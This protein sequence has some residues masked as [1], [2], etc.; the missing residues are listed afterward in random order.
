MAPTTLL[1]QKTTT[2]PRGRDQQNE[3]SPLKVAELIATL[4]APV[5]VE[6][7][8]ITDPKQTNRVRRAVRK[9]LQVQ[10]ENKG[11]SLIEILSAC[12]SGWKMT[13]V[14]AKQWIDDHMLK[15]YPLGVF[16]DKT[17][18]V[19]ASE[20]RKNVFITT[21]L[22]ETIDIPLNGRFSPVKQKAKTTVQKP[23]IIIAGFGGQGVL[24][25]GIGLAQ[26]GMLAGYHV[27][28]LP[29]YG[30]EMRGGTANCHVNLSTERIGSPLVS[31]PNVL[32]AMN[33]PSLE[34]FE[35]QVEPGGLVIYDTS[36][37]KD[38]AKT[39]DVQVLGI[40]ATEIADSLGDS[41]AANMVIMGAYIAHTSILE[42]ATVFEALPGFLKRKHLVPLNQ[43]AIEKGMEFVTNH[44]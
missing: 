10:I 13:S 17:E 33:L 37:I 34:K 18:T 30:P 16:K 25:F 24:L 19:Q 36:L 32:I 26:A 4:E 9:G 12:P 7:V 5:Y 28:W 21:G 6:R 1:G 29:S 39:S 2:S 20:P 14:Q 27:S 23:R 22:K 11:F 44:N 15:T 31:R 42:K 8:A 35:K 40:P 38:P 41:R 3:G 43:K